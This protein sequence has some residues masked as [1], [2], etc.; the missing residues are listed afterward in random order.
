MN[1]H[2]AF[3]RSMMALTAAIG[4]VVGAQA[5]SKPAAP[6]GVTIVIPLAAAAGKSRDEVVKAMQN[7]VAVIRKQPGLIDEVLMENKNPANKPTHVHV[8][9]WREM[10]NW[11]MVFANADFQKAMA[12]NAGFFA[13]DGA[14][15]YTP[16]K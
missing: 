16:I 12:A 1:R 8:T 9:R 7:I 15:I 4:M 5:Q 13:V 10:K 11:E 3:I 6:E 2:K 14:G